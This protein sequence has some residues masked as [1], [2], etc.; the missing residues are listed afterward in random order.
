[1]GFVLF[2][3]WAFLGVAGGLIGWWFPAILMAIYMIIMEG[4]SGQTLGKILMKVKVVREDMAP[5]TM[6][7]AQSRA[8]SIL[9]YP[10]VVPVILDLMW[11]SEEGQSLGDRWA[12]TIVM[13]VA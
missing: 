8:F 5:A 9:L 10:L 2:P 3:F 1:V 6:K 13:K 4:S 12:K 7:E 11:V